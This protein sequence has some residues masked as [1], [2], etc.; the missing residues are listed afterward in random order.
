M[1]MALPEASMAFSR[2]EDLA[3]SLLAMVADTG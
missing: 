1:I 2:F 3:K